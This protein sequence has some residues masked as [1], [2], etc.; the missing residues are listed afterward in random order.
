MAGANFTFD[1]FL[2]DLM[3]FGQSPIV[4]GIPRG[5]SRFGARPNIPAR[6]ATAGAGARR[7]GVAPGDERL[8]DFIENN[9]SNTLLGVRG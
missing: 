8:M 1:D 6:P 3:G 4:Q 9:R 5:T 7:R 2:V